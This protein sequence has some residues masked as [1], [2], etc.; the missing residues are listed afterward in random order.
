M[1]TALKE[2]YGALY[3]DLRDSE[4]F[5]KYFVFTA[6]G[7]WGEV[8]SRME[9]ARDNPKYIFTGT[10]GSGKTSEMLGILYKLGNGC[11]TYYTSVEGW[12]PYEEY[13]GPTLEL[14]VLLSLTE[15]CHMHGREAPMLSE[16]GAFIE[17][18]GVSFDGGVSAEKLEKVRVNLK[19]RG[20]RNEVVALIKRQ[21]KKP[22]HILYDMLLSL[23][24]DGEV[25]LCVDGM[26]RIP[27]HVF[28]DLVKDHHQELNALPCRI[29]YT[30]P[31]S[32]LVSEYVK[33]TKHFERC[34]VLPP[35]DTAPTSP[36]FL[37]VSDI[38]RKRLGTD[39]L[40]DAALKEAVRYS[41]GLPGLLM[42][43]L[44]EACV[45]ARSKGSDRI[46]KLVLSEAVN[47]LRDSSVSSLTEEERAVLGTLEKSAEREVFLSMLDEGYILYRRSGLKPYEVPPLFQAVKGKRALQQ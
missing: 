11:S 24:G 7:V 8:V 34:F 3:A 47:E 28:V 20:V 25:V 45:R 42:K 6:H 29:L 12:F 15:W 9:M 19:L 10:R 17:P 1:S 39:V 44:R 40:D 41:S 16:V 26:D 43:I 23:K 4:Q 35:P 18:T 30:A 13:S 46:S 14:A 27:I 21:K 22:F 32:V 37:D 36:G 38:V 5:R 33:Y 31:V 2:A